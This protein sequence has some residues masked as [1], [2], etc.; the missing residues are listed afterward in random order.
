LASRK[1][2][3]GRSTGC[4]AKVTVSPTRASVMVLIPLTM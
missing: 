2:L 1:P 3:I 4:W